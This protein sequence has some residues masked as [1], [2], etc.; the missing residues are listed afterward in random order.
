MAADLLDVL[1]GRGGPAFG[2][3]VR[4]LLPAARAV[5]EEH[6]RFYM[7]LLVEDRPGVIAAVSD[8]LG[9][10]KISIESILQT[11]ARDDGRDGG[12]VPIVLTTQ[13]CAR[14]SLEAAAAQIQSLE[15][16]VAAPRIMPIEET[17]VPRFRT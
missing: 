7:R 11:P 2:K 12:A 8:R 10:E 6:G 1:H 17:H 5:P 13:P 14:A 15:A 3:V 4:D 9:R 16:A